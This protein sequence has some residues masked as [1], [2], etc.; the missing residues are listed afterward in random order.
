M[1]C[2]LDEH[3]GHVSVETSKGV[4]VYTRS[5][6]SRRLHI[7][8]WSAKSPVIVKCVRVTHQDSCYETYTETNSCLA[9]WAA[10]HD[11]YICGYKE[12]R[13]KA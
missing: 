1:I 5:I 12:T 10:D 13:K 4:F 6:D 9:V 11:G 7:S 2:K 3:H 8:G